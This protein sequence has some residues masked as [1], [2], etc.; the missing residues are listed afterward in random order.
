[1][2]FLPIEFNL[3]KVPNGLQERTVWFNEKKFS[4]FSEMQLGHGGYYCKFVD[5][6]NGRCLVHKSRAFSCDFELLRFVRR[7]DA[8]WLGHRLYGRGWNMLKCD[9]K[10]GALCKMLPFSEEARVDIIRKLNRLIEWCD[11]FGLEHKVNGIIKWVECGPH[12]VRLV[13]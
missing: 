13:L 6:K 11:Y 5:T 9:G 2:D 4:I 8:V 3:G 12:K 1:M 10:R 7:K